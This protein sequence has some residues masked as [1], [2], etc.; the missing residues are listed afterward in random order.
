EE[1]LKGRPI[2]GLY[3]PTE[4]QSRDDFSV[5]RKAKNR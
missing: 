5:W 1:V 3:P 2:I 4:Q